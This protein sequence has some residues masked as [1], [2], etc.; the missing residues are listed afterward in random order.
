MATAGPSRATAG[1]G[2]HYRGV[3]S[4]SPHS[5]CLDIEKSKAARGRKRGEGCPLTIRLGVRWSSGVAIGG[6]GGFKPP[7]LRK[8]CIFYC[9]VTEQ[10]Q[11]LIIKIGATRCRILRLK[12]TKFRFRLPAGGAHSAP[13]DPLAAFKRRTSKGREGSGN[14]KGRGEGG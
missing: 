5:V 7:S 2:K 1:S 13:P 14:E 9:L 12:C 4:V 3:L 10:K 8:L 11:W 6:F